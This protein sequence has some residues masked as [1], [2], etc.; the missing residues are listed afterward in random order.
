MENEIEIIIVKC[1]WGSQ[2]AV[3]SSIGSSW[4]LFTS[5]G[6]VNRLT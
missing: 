5:G 1:K 3:S 4:S 2:G 6:Q